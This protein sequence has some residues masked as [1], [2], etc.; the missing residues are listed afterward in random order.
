MKRLNLFANLLYFKYSNVSV[1]G[2]R[3]L[4]V[5]KIILFQV[6]IMEYMRDSLIIMDMDI[7]N[8]DMGITIIMDII[9]MDISGLDMGMGID[10]DIRGWA[11]A[12][13]SWLF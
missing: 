8:M 10:M 9:N 12:W 11:W 7:M 1:L 4:N 3:N 2:L 13:A 5:K 6:E